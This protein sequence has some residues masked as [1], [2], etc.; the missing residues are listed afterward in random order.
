MVPQTGNVDYKTTVE[1]SLTPDNQGAVSLG[2]RIN[3]SQVLV[4]SSS[5]TLPRPGASFIW[6]KTIGDIMT[7]S[8]SATPLNP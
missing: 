5:V 6:T 2:I 7:G 8:S 1:V 3:G 4:L